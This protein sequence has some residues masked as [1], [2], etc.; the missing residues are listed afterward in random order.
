MGAR[1]RG[2][3][4]GWDLKGRD[5]SL[6]QIPTCGSWFRGRQFLAIPRP[7]ILLLICYQIL[8]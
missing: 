7:P 5:W 3:G 8:E 1:E 6:P 4:A 2:T